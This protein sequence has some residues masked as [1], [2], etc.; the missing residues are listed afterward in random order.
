MGVRVLQVLVVHR[1][2]QVL[3]EVVVHQE[4]LAQLELQ[5]LRGH[6]EVLVHQVV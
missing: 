5:V 1:V 2:L 6:R 4:V 3:V